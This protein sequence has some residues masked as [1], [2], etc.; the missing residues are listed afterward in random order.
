LP[1]NLKGLYFGANSF[2]GEKF[3][4]MKGLDLGH[5][6]QRSARSLGRRSGKEGKSTT[7]GELRPEGTSSQ[8]FATLH[9]PEG[10]KKSFGG[11]YTKTRKISPTHKSNRRR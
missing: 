2:V 5:S 4:E 8:D 11:R 10:G 1:P 9:A 7:W 6:W 3:F